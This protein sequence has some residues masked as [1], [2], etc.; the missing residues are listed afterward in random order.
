MA[1]AQR[2]QI[3]WTV[4]L[5]VREVPPLAEAIDAVCAR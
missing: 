3:K 4:D 5:I 2:E 1:E